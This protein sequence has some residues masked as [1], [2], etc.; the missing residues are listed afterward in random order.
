MSKISIQL[1]IHTNFWTKNFPVAIKS[2]VFKIS[3]NFRQSKSYRITLCFTAKTEQYV[4][5]EF[6]IV[7]MWVLSSVFF[8]FPSS[9]FGKLK[10]C[11][12][13]LLLLDEVKSKSKLIFLGKS[14][15][16][17]ESHWSPRWMFGAY[18]R[19]LKD[20]RVVQCGIGECEFR[21]YR[22][23]GFQTKIWENGH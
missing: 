3:N 9:E 22:Y 12:R 2:S 20:G 11:N 18:L 21:R 16:S 13:L 14:K 1:L 17:H 10:K 6:R 23:I 19:L 7:L 5:S 8:I 4:W 15:Y